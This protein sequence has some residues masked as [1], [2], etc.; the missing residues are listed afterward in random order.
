VET[1]NEQLAGD[2]EELIY[3]KPGTINVHLYRGDTWTGMGPFR[4]AIGGSAPAADLVSVRMQ[5]RKK[6]L[7]PVVLE[8][9]SAVSEEITIT[10]ANEWRWTIPAQSLALDAG[11]YV[12]DLETVDATDVVRTPI[13][14]TIRVDQDITREAEA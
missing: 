6:A 3:M 7:G 12:Y 13:E 1:R 9:S 5:I 11:R 2:R 10:S 14:G 4:L 8:L